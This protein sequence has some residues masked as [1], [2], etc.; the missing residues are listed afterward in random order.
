M[1]EIFSSFFS[2]ANIIALAHEVVFSLTQG[3]A[4]GYGDIGL[5]ARFCLSFYTPS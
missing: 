4:L 2:S 5:S 1:K 3:D